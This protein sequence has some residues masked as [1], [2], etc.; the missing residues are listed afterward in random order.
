MYARVMRIE[1]N[2]SNLGPYHQ[3]HKFPETHFDLFKHLVLEE[4]KTP[5]LHE[6]TP[7]ANKHTNHLVGD[8][9]DCSVQNLLSV[10][11][12]NNN[13]DMLFGFS[14]LKQV[15]DWFNTDELLALQKFGFNLVV[16]ET[17]TDNVI[18]FRKQIILLKLDKAKVLWK[19]NLES[20]VKHS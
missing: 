14:N 8:L 2:E 9:L 17:N 5:P 3:V 15:K 6:D 16:Y 10:F 18:K 13:I 1:H 7:L 20:L 19:Q 4:K 12:K 11:K